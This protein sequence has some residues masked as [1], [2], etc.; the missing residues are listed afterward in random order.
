MRGAVVHGFGLMVWFGWIGPMDMG[1][2]L[3]RLIIGLGYVGDCWLALSFDSVLLM[4]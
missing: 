3:L 4:V 2:V 1:L